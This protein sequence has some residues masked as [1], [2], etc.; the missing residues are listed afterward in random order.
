LL[1][2]LGKPTVKFAEM[3]F[4]QIGVKDLL[5]ILLIWVIAYQILKLFRRTRASYIF[6]GVLLVVFFVLFA[7]F[8]NFEGLNWI[9]SAIKTVGLVALVVVFQPEIRRM[10]VSIGR[11]PA[12]RTLFREESRT[13]SEAV[14]ASFG[15]R[16]RGLGG[17][18]VLGRRV[19][20]K[21]YVEESGVEL[22]A[23]VSSPLILSIFTP[24]SPLHDGAMIIEADKI[25][26]AR[27]LLPLSTNPHLEGTLGT[28]HRAAI[29]VTEITDA[30][31]VVVSEESRVVRTALGG[32][33]STPHTKESLAQTIE[34][35]F[36]RKP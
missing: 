9:F 8:L 33:L 24:P 12:V 4:L 3:E 17:I 1:A 25:V 2:I 6:Y 28:R 19:G 32:K 35:M 16:D 14:K 26:A 10:L 7:G 21:E 23:G 11:N 5:D 34:A 30:L 36:A 13:I 31:A 22:S 15:L 18:I 20:L 27:V 29:G